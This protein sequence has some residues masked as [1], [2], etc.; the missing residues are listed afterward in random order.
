MWP[1]QT[2]LPIRS[3]T[4]RRFGIQEAALEAASFCCIAGLVGPWRITG[5]G[6]DSRNANIDRC[7][8][9]FRRLYLHYALQQ[10]RPFTHA[11]Q[12]QTGRFVR[13]FLDIK[14]DTIVLDDQ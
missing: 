14:P 10:R 12:S 5:R 7:S 4:A 11:D 1:M 2:S 6:K 13:L 8:A 9:A 3:K